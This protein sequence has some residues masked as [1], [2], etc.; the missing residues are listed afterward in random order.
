MIQGLIVL[1]VSTDVIALRI[2]RRGRMLVPGRRK[3][4]AEESS[5]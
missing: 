1:M 5:P 3:P 2:L 4:V